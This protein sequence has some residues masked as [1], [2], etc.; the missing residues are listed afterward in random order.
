MPDR[1]R[2]EIDEGYRGSDRE[3]RT[4]PDSLE[5]EEKPDERN[6]PR[7]ARQLWEHAPQ[8]DQVEDAESDHGLAEGGGWVQRHVLAYDELE[9]ARPDD[10]F[11]RYSS[12]ATESLR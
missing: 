10:A 3:E 2:P 9:N 12:H 8:H 7:H 6:Q 5:T 11:P 1:V 4:L